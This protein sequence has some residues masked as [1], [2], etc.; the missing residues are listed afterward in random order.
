MMRSERLI[1]PAAPGCSKGVAEFVAPFRTRPREDVPVRC[2]HCGKLTAVR[3]VG[4]GE[5]FLYRCRRCNG[6][7]KFTATGRHGSGAINYRVTKIEPA[8]Q[9]K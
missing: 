6:F 7:H 8:S 3:T 5:E 9:D 1:E 4:K 2:H